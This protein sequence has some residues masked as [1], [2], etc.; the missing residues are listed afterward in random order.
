MLLDH[1]GNPLEKSPA[2][3]SRLEPGG[4]GSALVEA[5]RRVVPRKGS[6][7]VLRA[8]RESPILRAIA[9]KI[10]V[11]VAS[12]EWFAGIETADAAEPTRVPGHPLALMLRKGNMLLNGLACRKTVALHYILAGESF[13]YIERDALGT[14]RVRYPIPPHWVQDVPSAIGET[15]TIQAPGLQRVEVPASDMVWHKDPDPSAPY[16]RGTGVGLALGDEL[17]AD[18]QAAILMKSVFA[19]RARPDIVVATNEK[20]EMDDAAKARIEARWKRHQGPEN[21]GRPHFSNHPIT[22]TPISH[23]FQELELKDLRAFERDIMVSVF[24][25]PPELLGILTNS[26][27]STIDS[28]E[29]L[30][31]KTVIAPILMALAASYDDQVCPQYDPALRAC[32][33]SPVVEDKEFRRGVMQSAPAAF[34][35]DEVRELAGL[36]PLDDEAGQALMAPASPAPAAKED[37]VEDKPGP[38]AKSLSAPALAISGPL[39]GSVNCVELKDE[40]GAWSCGTEKNPADGGDPRGFSRSGLARMAAAVMSTG[41]LE[42]LS[43]GME[44]TGRRAVRSFLSTYALEVSFDLVNERALGAIRRDAVRRARGIDA[45]TVG[46]LRTA[47]HAGVG[48]GEGIEPLRQRVRTIFTR[49]SN[50]RAEAIARTETVRA[51][52]M[53]NQTIMKEAD[54]EERQWLSVQ[55]DRTRDSHAAL[56]GMIVGIDRPFYIDGDSAMFPGDFASAENSINCRCTTIP[57]IDGLSKTGRRDRWRTHEKARSKGEGEFKGKLSRRFQKQAAAVLAEF[58]RIAREGG[59]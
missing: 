53:S 59:E 22:V 51:A 43:P 28:A 49:A 20:V 14:P 45:R 1:R 47:I 48:L 2:S 35:V 15:F 9:G 24:G 37:P 4:Y 25:F 36:G 52:N 57:W 19:N 42:I 17:A 58:D 21:A 56:D 44:A 18:E 55:D 11:M 34:S 32:F 3:A 39:G 50:A 41:I 7:E 31:N 26:N 29:Y 12:V 16:E 6:V 40:A 33:V 23:T 8:Y 30:A 54:I 10:S 5:P 38:A 27:R 13:E 46:Q